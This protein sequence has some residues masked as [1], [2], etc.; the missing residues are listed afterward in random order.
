MS[1]KQPINIHIKKDIE[2]EPE[3]IFISRVVSSGNG[4]VI[5][6]FKRFKG[7]NVIVLVVDKMKGCGA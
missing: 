6:S 1:K 2:V 4:A 3:N 7:K 5:K